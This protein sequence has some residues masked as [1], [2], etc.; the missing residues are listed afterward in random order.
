MIAVCCYFVIGG[1]GAVVVGMCPFSFD[2]TA[3]RLFISCVFNGCGQP[4]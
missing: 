3:V 1:V 4:H 2:F